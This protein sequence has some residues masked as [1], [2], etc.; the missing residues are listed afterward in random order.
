MDNEAVKQ[1]LALDTAWT[2]RARQAWL[3]LMDLAVWGDLGSSRL[4]T[5]ARVKKWTLEVGEK[6]K[7][8]TSDRNWIP[9]PREQLKS[10][11]AEQRWAQLLDSQYRDEQ[12]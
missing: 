11:L 6:L 1:A 3:T 5:V 9:H 7:S 10:A 8:L 2:S 4:G 12:G